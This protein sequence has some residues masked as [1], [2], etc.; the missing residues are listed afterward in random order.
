M[1]KCS[2]YKPM[3][4]PGRRGSN[5][6]SRTWRQRLGGD[7]GQEGGYR[8]K[9]QEDATRPGAHHSR[10]RPMSILPVPGEYEPF[11]MQ[12]WGTCPSPPHLFPFVNESNQF[13]VQRSFCLCS[14][15]RATQYHVNHSLATVESND[16]MR[17]QQCL[18]SI[19]E[20]CAPTLY[21][22]PHHHLSF[23]SSAGGD[24]RNPGAIPFS[25]TWG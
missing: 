25:F 5:R 12:P 19:Q 2:S 13:P 3:I 16:Y 18:G 4:R 21:H 11:A 20:F 22:E 24:S 17:C 6:R 7:E 23:R 1:R 9:M 8:C 10:A 15:C 14:L